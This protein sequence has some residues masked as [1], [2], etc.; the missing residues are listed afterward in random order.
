MVTIGE[1]QNQLTELGVC[2]YK[3]LRGYVIEQIVF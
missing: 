3:G 2:G 1:P